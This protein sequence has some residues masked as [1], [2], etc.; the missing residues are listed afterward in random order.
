M[1]PGPGS[2]CVDRAGGPKS[3]FS[4]RVRGWG[5]QMIPTEMVPKKEDLIGE[6]EEACPGG[7]WSISVRHEGRVFPGKFRE[8]EP[9]VWPTQSRPGTTWG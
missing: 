2:S 1:L 8:A 7:S 9:S 6:A 3:V 5:A 4:V